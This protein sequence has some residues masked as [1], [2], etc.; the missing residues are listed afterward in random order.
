MRDFLGV[1]T[2]QQATLDHEQ[3]GLPLPAG[4]AE[5]PLAS[6]PTPSKAIRKI[7]IR[8]RKQMLQRLYP[9]YTRLCSFAHVLPESTFFKTLFNRNHEIRKLINVSDIKDRFQQDM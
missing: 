3:L 5:T 2:A 6:F 1:T 7:T 9:E 8:E 4:V